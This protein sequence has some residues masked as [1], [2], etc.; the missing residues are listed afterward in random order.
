MKLKNKI[1]RNYLMLMFLIL[2]AL[3]DCYQSTKLLTKE[4][5]EIMRHRNE[6]SRKLIADKT[7][8]LMK[9]FF[10][11]DSPL[12]DNELK[13]KEILVPNT[14]TSFLQLEN[15]NAKDGKNLGIL[16]VFI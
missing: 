15:R 2:L 16:K 12:K 4:K 5:F 13:Y 3:F 6:N 8:N 11:R 14:S 10:N 7:N 9:V 1:K